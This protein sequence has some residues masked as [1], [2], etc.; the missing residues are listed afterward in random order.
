MMVKAVSLR[1]HVANFPGGDS[2]FDRAHQLLVKGAQIIAHDP[3]EFRRWIPSLRAAPAADNS[4]CVARKS[5]YRST[6]ASSRSRG[7]WL[8]RAAADRLLAQLPKKIFQ[9]RAMQAALISE[10]VVEHRLVRVRRRGD[11]LRARAGQ[12]LCGEMLLGRRQNAPRRRR[13]LD[14][15]FVRVAMFCACATVPS[16]ASQQ[17]S[18]FFN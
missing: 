8:S 7:E 5:K 4:G 2:F 3:V 16:A 15:F 10:I 14:L 17:E 6:N 11:F 1:I 13:I 18:A 12:P 9:H